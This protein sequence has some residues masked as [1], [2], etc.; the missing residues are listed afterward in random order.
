MRLVCVR[1]LALLSFATSSVSHTYAAP[2]EDRITLARIG[3]SEEPVDL[4]QFNGRLLVG[5]RDGMIR[6]VS[7]GAVFLDIAHLVSPNLLS[8]TFDDSHI[9]TLY[10]RPDS[11]RVARFAI[12]EDH[13]DPDSEEILLDWGLIPKG[14]HNAG[15]LQFGGDGYLYWSIGD[16]DVHGNPTN[17]SQDKTTILGSILKLSVDGTGSPADCIPEAAYA[18]PDDNP[19]VDG[20]GGAC[21]EIW[22]YGLR[23]PWRFSFD[24]QTNDLWIGDVGLDQ[25]EEVNFSVAD[26]SGQNFGWVCYEGSLPFSS[27]EGIE[28]FVFAVYEYGHDG[29]RCSVTG[30]YVYHGTSID[31]LAERYIFADFCSGEIFAIGAGSD[32]ETIY[33]EEGRAWVT[34]GVDDLGE[35]YVADYNS[36]Q[37]FRLISH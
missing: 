18:I 22:Q 12:I 7:D 15:Q 28:D 31:Q 25:R 32:V 34:F 16:G 30:G 4:G 20:P 37:I 23:Q 26:K 5:E 33:R 9:Y 2:Q 21:D 1:L 10:R 11:I 17:S 29:G 14:I 13:A 27:C 19:F 36:G 3:V 35:L 6:D 24:A 8:F